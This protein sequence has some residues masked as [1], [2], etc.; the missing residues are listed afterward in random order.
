MVIGDIGA[1]DRRQFA[2]HADRGCRRRYLRVPVANDSLAFSWRLSTIAVVFVMLV[3]YKKAIL[4]C[5]S[6]SGTLQV[7]VLRVQLAGV[8]ARLAGALVPPIPSA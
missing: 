4:G 6:V 3:A 7:I 8:L 1:E 2:F 5:Q